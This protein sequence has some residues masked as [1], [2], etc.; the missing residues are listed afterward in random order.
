MKKYF[1]ILPLLM[2]VFSFTV[3]VTSAKDIKVPVEETP[4]ETGLS[5]DEYYRQA[6]ALQDEERD[7]EAILIFNTILEIEPDYVDVIND[8][9]VS[10]YYLRDY[11]NAIA[12]FSRAIE[13]NPTY[14]RAYNNLANSYRQLGDY[15]QALAEYANAIELNP[16][17][18]LAYN[19][20]GIAYRMMEEYDLA[21]E[22]YNTALEIDPNEPETYSNI[23]YLY[24]QLGE[25]D[26]AL[27]NFNQAITLD[28]QQGNAQDGIRHQ[29]ERPPRSRQDGQDDKH[30]DHLST[31]DEAVNHVSDLGCLG[32][33]LINHD[34][35]MLDEHQTHSGD[36]HQYTHGLPE[37][38]KGEPDS[39]QTSRTE[40]Q[41]GGIV[42]RVGVPTPPVLHGLV[43]GPGASRHA[44]ERVRQQTHTERDRCK[45]PSVRQ[46]ARQCHGGHHEPKQGQQ[47]SK[48]LHVQPFGSSMIIITIIHYL[49]INVNTCHLLQ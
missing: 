33:T 31:V 38:Q 1:R 37:W 3:F 24:N 18:V 8:R 39:H 7:E 6:T 5:V 14:A 25:F 48:V 45:T 22:T 23:G 42:E 9:G 19:N 47:I 16:E 13:L 15:D 36:A 2:V 27:E 34:L 17:Y 40:S 10:Y 11:D 44:I 29:D 26:L 46:R 30:R 12:D 43:I 20:M 4:V 32:S 35:D 49:Y 28:P 41:I 21:L